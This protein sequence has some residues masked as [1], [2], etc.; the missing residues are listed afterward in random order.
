MLVSSLL[1]SILEGI[2]SIAARLAVTAIISVTFAIFFFLQVIM[3]LT[4]II[5]IYPSEGLVKFGRV[6]P[7][8][9][10]EH[11]NEGSNDYR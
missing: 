1:Q 6:L 8:T 10:V 9:L 5:T 2:K 3:P 11:S 7:I 4:E